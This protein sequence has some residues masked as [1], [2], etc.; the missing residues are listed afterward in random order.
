MGTVSELLA[1]RTSLGV[2][3]ERDGRRKSQVVMVWVVWLVF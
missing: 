1:G 2:A 3:S